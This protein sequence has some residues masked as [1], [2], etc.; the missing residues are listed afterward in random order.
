LPSALL[1]GLSRVSASRMTGDVFLFLA[2]WALFLALWESEL[3]LNKYG[4]A[5]VLATRCPSPCAAGDSPSCRED[6]RALIGMQ[7]PPL[8]GTP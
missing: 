2:R 1:E 8:S 5:D 6:H 4:N 3:Q 7:L